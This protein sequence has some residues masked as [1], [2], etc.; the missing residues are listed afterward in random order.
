VF[1]RGQKVCPYYGEVIDEPT[2]IRRYGKYTALYGIKLNRGLYEDASLMRGI[3]SF[4]NS[5]TN[6]YFSI[7]R[8]NTINIVASEN[9]KN[10]EE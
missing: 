2:L 6:C 9:I 1:T 7:G 5:Q 3:G 10:Y 8:N 4:I